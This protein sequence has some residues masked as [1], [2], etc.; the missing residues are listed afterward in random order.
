[1]RF[2]GPAAATAA[3]SIAS[4]Y[5]GLND[6]FEQS[7][8]PPCVILSA[9]G[10]ACPSCGATRSAHLLLHGDIAGALDYNALLVLIVPVALFMLIR[11]WIASGRGWLSIWTIP[12]VAG[13]FAVALG[14]GVVRNLPIDSLRWLSV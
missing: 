14:W 12:R 11:W 1:M 6:P 4:A 5:V 8:F 3:G 13:A 9:T 2:V 7:L 10:F